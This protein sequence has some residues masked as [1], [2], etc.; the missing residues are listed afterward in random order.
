[1]SKKKFFFDKNM[2]N[3]GYSEEL[4]RKKIPKNNVLNDKIGPNSDFFPPPEILAEYESL[5]PGILMHLVEIAKKEQQH[6]H[7][8]EIS[9]AEQQKKIMCLGRNCSFLFIMMFLSL[10][11]LVCIFRNISTIFIVSILVIIFTFA[12]LWFILVKLETNIVSTSKKKIIINKGKNN[13][14][15][16][17]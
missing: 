1:M 16:I 10:I 17:R 5:H 15:N 11:L 13:V 6:R 3:R 14:Q 7:N 12:I 4:R 8:L 2:L 9:N